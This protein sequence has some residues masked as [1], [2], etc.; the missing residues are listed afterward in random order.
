MF[1]CSMKTRVYSCNLPVTCL[2]YGSFLHTDTFKTR[3]D[4]T[5]E[6]A[7]K[8]IKL[9]NYFGILFNLETPEDLYLP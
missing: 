4:F 2:K 8:R 3:Y 7:Q 1:A 9:H 6:F 5:K